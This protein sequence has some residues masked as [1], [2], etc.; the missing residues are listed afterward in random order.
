MN[1]KEAF[2]TLV[3]GCAGGL[4]LLLDQILKLLARTNEHFTFYIIKPFLGWEFFR[5][6]GIA[7]SLPLTQLIV[8]PLSFIIIGGIVIYTAQKQNKP[9]L[10]LWGT[11]LIVSGALSNIIDRMFLGFTTDYIRIIFSV[12]NLADICIVA[13]AL[14]VLLSEY[15]HRTHQESE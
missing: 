9:P 8:L 13:G 14:L 12:I 1:Q 2:T 6:F 7:F 5:N 3:A 4:F 15:K 11:A 10:L